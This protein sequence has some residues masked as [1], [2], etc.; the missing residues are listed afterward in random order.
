MT[1]P[2]LNLQHK[3]QDRMRP[4]AAATYLGVSP[5]TLAMWRCTQ[6]GPAFCKLGGRIF[7]KLTDLNTWIDE[8]SDLISSSQARALEDMRKVGRLKIKL[9]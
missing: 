4:D 7:Y 5:K 6:K 3:P 8:R 2:D 9:A 1:Y